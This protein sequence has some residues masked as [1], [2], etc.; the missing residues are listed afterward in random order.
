MHKCTVVIPVK[1]DELIHRAIQSVPEGVEIVVGLSNSPEEFINSLREKYG[2]AIRLAYSN[3]DGMPV[4]LNK[5]VEHATHES[6][7]VLDSDCYIPSAT[8]LETYAR[9]LQEYKFVRGITL[10]ERDSYWSRVAAKGTEAMNRRFAEKARLFGPSIAFSKSAYQAYGGY[11]EAL[12][13]GSCD[14]EFCLRIEENNER[15]GFAEEAVIIHKPLSF[16]VDFKSHYGYGLGMRYIDIKFGFRYGLGICLK[17]VH[18][19][20]LMKKLVSRGGVSLLRSVFLGVVM[21]YGYFRYESVQS[22]AK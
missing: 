11:D 22:Y 21:L 10:M 17:K 5:A 12:V 9:Y 19:A 8:T 7:I 1:K 20:E 16:R 4:A 3:K 6:I 13:Y 14:H 2:P 15:V 18:P